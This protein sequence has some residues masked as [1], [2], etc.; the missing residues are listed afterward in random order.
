MVNGLKFNN[1][2]DVPGIIYHDEYAEVYTDPREPIK[3]LD[4]LPSPKVNIGKGI[5]VPMFTSRGCPYNCVFCASTKHWGKFRQFSAEYVKTKIYNLVEAGAKSILF[6]DDLFIAD[7][8]RFKKIADVVRHL[9]VTFHG[10]ARSNLLSEE[11]CKLLKVMG[12]TSIRF[13]A[14]TG[15]PKLLK[16]LKNNSVTIKDHQNAIDNCNKVDLRVGGSFVFG[17]PGETLE[18]LELTRD[19]L[20][21][22]AGKFE[23]MGFYILSPIPG[24]QL[25]NY[26]LDKKLVSYDMDW[27]KL[28]QDPRR[29][30]FDWDNMIYLG[31]EIPKDRFIEEVNLIMDEFNVE[32]K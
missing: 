30:A 24:T 4:S 20:R 1:L 17:T 16:F 8:H 9:P 26:A 19:F 22:N 29:K 28:N 11:V 5:D 14:E 25:W 10:F 12:F 6:H 32:V 3:N 31:D 7:F 21:K 2:A 13:G 18:D 15:S 27:N 23:I